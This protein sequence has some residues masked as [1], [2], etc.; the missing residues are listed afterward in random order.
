MSFSKGDRVVHAGRPEWGAGAVLSAESYL[1]EG[2]PAQ[3]LS[4]RFDRAGTKSISTAFADLRPASDMPRL[5]ESPEEEPDPIAQ[6]ALNA[7]VEELMTRLPDRATD[8]FSSLRSRLTATLDLYRFTESG[9]ALLDWAAIQTG[10]K[11]P[12]SR[13]NRHE[14]EQWFVK[15]K[16]ELDNH[17]RKLLR[18]VRKQ[19]PATIDAVLATTN[20]AGKA[21]VRR[22]EMR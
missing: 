2:K 18:D 10:L 9:G 11:D 7:N 22:V 1:H 6:A 15:F 16:I 5:L 8:P 14:L 20:P 17:L 21:A 13:F 19:E 4:I 12:L 3:R